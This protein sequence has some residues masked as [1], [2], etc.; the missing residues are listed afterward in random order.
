M[1]NQI[2]ISYAGFKKIF[3]AIENA[4]VYTRLGSKENSTFIKS[5]NY[6]QSAKFINAHMDI[7]PF[8]EKQ[9]KH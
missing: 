5:Y 4:I 9:I 1:K 3:S 2:K 8:T 6:L 7:N